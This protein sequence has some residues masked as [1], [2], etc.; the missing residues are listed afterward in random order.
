MDDDKEVDI[1]GIARMTGV[2][3][4]GIKDATVQ[5]PP[6]SL[7]QNATIVVGKES[8]RVDV[9]VKI[10]SSRKPELSAY[11]RLPQPVFYAPLGFH[12]TKTSWLLNSFSNFSIAVRI[13]F[14]SGFSPKNIAPIRT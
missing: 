1:P 4:I 8:C 3:R 7:S 12:F 10:Q 6:I 9:D 14:Q 2:L 5:E 11:S 13:N